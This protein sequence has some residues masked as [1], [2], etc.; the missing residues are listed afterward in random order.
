MAGKLKIGDVVRLKSGGPLLTIIDEQ[1]NGEANVK[2]GWFTV[3]GRNQYFD[4][5]IHRE[6]LKLEYEANIE[7]LAN[8]HPKPQ[9]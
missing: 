6:A 9:T 2:V 7:R 8:I 3:D 4:A 5:W 1:T